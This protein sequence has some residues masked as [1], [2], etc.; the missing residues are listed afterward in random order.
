MI[1]STGKTFKQML[2]KVYTEHV[3]LARLT[4][5][6]KEAFYFQASYDRC[7]YCAWPETALLAKCEDRACQGA[8]AEKSAILTDVE[9]IYIAEN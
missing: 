4:V 3:Q 9:Y 2:D 6:S 5:E 8:I 7:L 1:Y